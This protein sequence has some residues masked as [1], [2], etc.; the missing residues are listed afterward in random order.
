[1]VLFCARLSTGQLR[2]TLADNPAFGV[3]N[4]S[5][6]YATFYED[7]EL[8][9]HSRSN[10]G[11]RVVNLITGA[12]EA[13][14]EALPLA[15]TYDNSTIFPEPAGGWGRGYMLSP[16]GAADGLEMHWALPEESASRR[17]RTAYGEATFAVQAAR[18][19]GFIAVGFS[20]GTMIGSKAVIGWAEPGSS[21]VALYDLGGKAPSMVT[22]APE[23]LINAS[24]SRENGMMTM[25]FTVALADVG[26]ASSGDQTMVWSMGSIVT[27][28]HPTYHGSTRGLFS[29]AL[30]GK[31]S[32]ALAEAEANFQVGT[33]GDAQALAVAL[34]YVSDVSRS[35]V[36]YDSASEDYEHVIDLSA[37]FRL[38]WTITAA[39]RVPNATDAI[40]VMLQ[41]RTRG[42]LGIGLMA[43]ELQ[44]GTA[45]HGSNPRP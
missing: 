42:W 45:R 29:V 18:S 1:M 23:E 8:K 35:E 28:A 14:V 7:D 21:S 36:L 15:I 9:Y 40:S 6:T 4:A 32:A 43:G 22:A 30:D 20:P 2:G 37:D 25:R 39:S 5:T 11:H 31:P 3:V 24:I 16:T 34:C 44:H 17:R 27:D 26:A 33:C 41:A 10:R 13:D 12:E 38:A 19:Q